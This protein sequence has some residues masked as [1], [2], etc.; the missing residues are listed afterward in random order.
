[1]SRADYA[2]WNED[3]DLI[4]WQEEGSHDVELDVDGWYDQ[5]DF[6]DE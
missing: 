6:D 5:E 4:W 1:M 2:H 3:Q